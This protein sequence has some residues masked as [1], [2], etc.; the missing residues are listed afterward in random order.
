VPPTP[1]ILRTLVAQ[2]PKPIRFILFRHGSSRALI[3]DLLL[4]GRHW[5]DSAH[6]LTR[7]RFLQHWPKLAALK[8]LLKYKYLQLFNSRNPMVFA[9]L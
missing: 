1:R 7:W 5:C 4:L 2:G 9:L 8:P 3:Q 6:S